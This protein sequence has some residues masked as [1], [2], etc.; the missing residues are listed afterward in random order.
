MRA[1][2]VVL[3]FRWLLTVVVLSALSQVGCRDTAVLSPPLGPS[4]GAVAAGAGGS[5]VAGTGV[6]TGTLGKDT[7]WTMMGRDPRNNYHNPDETLLNVTN[8]KGLKEKWVFEVAGFPPGSPVV[9]D[10][11][12]FV[13]STGGTYAIDFKTGAQVWMREIGGTASVAYADGFIYV[14]DS[15]AQLYKLKATDGTTV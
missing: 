7:T 13:M 15:S 1:A 11:K 14:H 8:A 2:D 9:A 3:A 12:V 10:G 4:G 6:G 5:G